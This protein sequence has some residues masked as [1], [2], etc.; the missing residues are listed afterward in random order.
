LINI[1]EGRKIIS[2]GP[3][4]GIKIPAKTNAEITGRNFGKELS[5]GA[6]FKSFQENNL[7][8]T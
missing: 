6:V 4:K 7:L 2:N 5:E 3:I 1:I 8:K